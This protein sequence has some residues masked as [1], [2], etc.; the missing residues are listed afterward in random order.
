MS[1]LNG[2]NHNSLLQVCAEFPSLQKKLARVSKKRIETTNQIKEGAK[3]KSNWGKLKMKGTLRQ[4]INK[5][6]KQ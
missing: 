1:S 4:A 5:N 3:G 6:G 2:F